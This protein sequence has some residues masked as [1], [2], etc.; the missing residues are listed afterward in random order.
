MAPSD[1]F[2]SGKDPSGLRGTPGAHAA[3]SKTASAEV[4][5]NSPLGDA[6]ENN[7]ARGGLG[8]LNC[9]LLRFAVEN[10]VQ[11]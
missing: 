9:V 10:N 2:Q 7:L 8:S 6:V 5:G 1:P 4:G 11:F 3:K